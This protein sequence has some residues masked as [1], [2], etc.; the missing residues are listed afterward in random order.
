M[1]ALTSSEYTCTFTKDEDLEI[2]RNLW[3]NQGDEISLEYSG[4]NA[5]KGDIVKYG[6]QTLSGLVKDGI[7]ALSRYYLNNFQ[8]GI[9]QDAVDLISGNYT[10]SGNSPSPFQLNKFES[11]TLFP[12]ASV[13]LIGSLTV[14]SITFNR[15]GHNAQNVISSVIC[16][17]A[18]AGM[19]ALVKANGR[20]IC[21]RPRLCGLL[22]RDQTG[23]DFK[24]ALLDTETQES[25]RQ[26][27]VMFAKKLLHKATKL[28]HQ[29]QNN[30]QILKGSLT[31]QDLDF[32]I[33][34]HYGIPS[35]ASLLAF[36]PIQR[37]LAIG[38]LDG[39]IKVIGG[40]NIEGLLISP[41]QLPF[42][43]L[44]FL[45][46]KGFL[47]SISNDN[48]IQVWNLEN[49][50][51]AS[52]LQWSSNITSFSVI[53][54]SFFMY[55]GDENGLMSVLK[56]EEDGELLVLPYHISTKS[57]TVLDM[58]SFS[59]SFLTESLPNPSSPVISMTWKSFVR[60]GGHVKSPKDAGPK[61]HDK[62]LEKLIFICTKDAKLYA[63]DGN[64]R[65]INSKPTQL[66][67]DTTAVSMHIIEGSTSI[68][69]SEERKESTQ[70]TKDV[71]ARNKP[72]S[73]TDQNK[74]ERIN[75]GQNAMDSLVL[76]CC[77]E[78]LRLYHLKSVVQGSEKP[79]LKVKLDKHCCWTSIFMK[80]EKT[81][82]LVLLYQSGELEIRSLPD[83]ELVKVTSL[84]SILRWS[85]KAN[86][87]RTMCSTENGQIAM[88]NG[89]EVAFLSLTKS[90][91]DLR[92]TETF[93]SLHDKVLAAAVEAVM[94]SS[95]NQKK[96]QGIPGALVNILKG[97]RGGKTKNNTNFPED[98][99]SGFSNLD[100][101][102]SKNPFPDPLE[103]SIS[104]QEDVELDIDDIEIDEPAPVSMP[105]SSHTKQKE[106][107]GKR[108]D[109]E[110]LLDGDNDEP[111]V[112]TR[113]EII[114]KYRKNAGDASSVAGQA[115]NKLLER[116]EKLEKISRRTQDLSNEAEDFASLANEL[117]KAM[118][119]RKWWQI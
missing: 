7:S 11:R 88:I 81:C 50:S 92:V 99:K 84:T 36:D 28:H 115:R 40:D 21:S 85:Y 39:R 10:V 54:G 72:T 117:V 95:H 56:H 8:D 2:F 37:V 96:K 44:E 64:N 48:D 5:L 66:K 61:N 29:H 97:F 60:N 31:P 4:T 58:N 112:R 106:K 19:M 27:A 91:D 23:E 116:Q 30:N 71:A 52:S 63:F 15:A 98:M 83:L 94:S 67:K 105:T 20:Q 59:V 45:A 79:L 35:T 76:L 9:R 77:K 42:K 74:T 43:Y 6:K 90:D 24:A 109:R 86:M 38:T 25:A 100:R 49:R 33:A 1:C 32:Q 68:V 78:A 46:N 18:T 101:I 82:G 87:Q 75:S 80:D 57:L 111:R 53:Y 119:R 114:A 108:T 55:V 70:F 47:V 69:E 118:E 22:E 65:M 110:M 89:S 93:P 104:D 102:F 3:V 16:A 103:S 73:E 51:I 17:G 62:N 34:A 113:E 13:L 41:K 14:T 26:A 12:V 107:I